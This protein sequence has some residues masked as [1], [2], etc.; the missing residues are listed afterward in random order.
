MSEE[1]RIE[2]ASTAAPRRSWEL[3]LS[4]RRSLNEYMRALES[5]I[6]DDFNQRSTSPQAPD[7]GESRLQQA[8]RRVVADEARSFE[9]IETVRRAYQ[10]GNRLIVVVFAAT[11]IL[12]VGVVALLIASLAIG[13][14]PTPSD[15]QALGL[16]A[17][18]AGMVTGAFTVAVSTLALATFLSGRRRAKAARES[19]FN[20]AYSH[21]SIDLELVI[22]IDEI[23]RDARARLSHTLGGV[24]QVL[25]LVDI[26]DGLVQEGVWSDD[27]ARHFIAA[28]RTRNAIVHEPDLK[29]SPAQ[30]SMH[31]SELR[32]LGDLI[33]AAKTADPR[34][35][36]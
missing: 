6:V 2:E 20:D 7:V 8:I 34:R 29:R 16:M 32:R 11:A 35:K 26:V 28:L 22:K 17:T 36:L 13:T 25:S 23:E 10:R 21:S 27:D 5:R 15:A 4:E 3:S 33:V 14:E 31:V 19:A 9:S 18:I 12:A 1:A 30:V 24:A